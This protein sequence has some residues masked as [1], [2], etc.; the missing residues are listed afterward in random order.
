MSMVNMFN[1]TPV[2]VSQI[3]SAIG[4][5]KLGSHDH[6]Q[7]YFLDTR[8]IKVSALKESAWNRFY[9]RYGFQFVQS[10]EF[11]N[12]YVRHNLTVSGPAC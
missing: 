1:Q 8:S 9:T 10:S 12:Y 6:R 5:E 2:H 3:A 4:T 11:D 7:A